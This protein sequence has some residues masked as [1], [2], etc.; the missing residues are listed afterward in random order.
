[1]G[2]EEFSLQNSHKHQLVIQHEGNKNTLLCFPAGLL[3]LELEKGYNP[4]IYPKVECWTKCLKTS[5]LKT[6]CLK[7][8]KNGIGPCFNMKTHLATI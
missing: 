8:Y 6:F 3:S 2:V 5:F 7:Y 1:M 4:I